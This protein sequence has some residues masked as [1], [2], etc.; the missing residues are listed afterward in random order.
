VLESFYEVERQRVAELMRSAIAFPS[1]ETVDTPVLL[2]ALEIYELDRLDFA[3]GFAAKTAASTRS[4]A[5]AIGFWVGSGALQAL[6]IEIPP[7]RLGRPN[8]RRR[9]WSSVASDAMV[10]G[11]LIVAVG[12]R[13]EAFAPARILGRPGERALRLAVVRSGEPA[14]HL[15]G[16]PARDHPR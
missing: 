8:L 2:R 1:I 3:E 15:D 6:G 13:R 12:Q 4:R 9:V 11:L 14:G 10:G 5:A 7:T 16:R